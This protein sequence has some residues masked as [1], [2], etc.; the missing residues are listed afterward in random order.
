MLRGHS[1]PACSI[2]QH[3]PCGGGVTSLHFSREYLKP[4]AGEGTP[5]PCRTAQTHSPSG[6][7]RCQ[8]SQTLP[9]SRDLLLL[10]WQGRIFQKM[11]MGWQ[12]SLSGKEQLEETSRGHSGAGRV[13]DREQ[14]PEAGSQSRGAREDR[15]GCETAGDRDFPEEAAQSLL[16]H[17]QAQ[18]FTGLSAERWK[19]SFQIINFNICHPH[20]G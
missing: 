7:G 4:P 8:C 9:G 1:V 15:A 20:R 13:R 11:C 18:K 12:R 2:A 14:E 10:L 5:L 17:R 6:H 3:R 16:T 19:F